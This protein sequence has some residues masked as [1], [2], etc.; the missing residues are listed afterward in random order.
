LLWLDPSVVG[1]G[2]VCGVS[3]VCESGCIWGLEGFNPIRGVESSGLA[4][5]VRVALIRVCGGGC[6]AGQAGLCEVG[7]LGVQRWGGVLAGL[8]GLGAQRAGGLVCGIGEGKGCVRAVRKGGLG[9]W[10]GRGVGACQGSV[11]NVA[12]S[13]KSNCEAAR[14]I[15]AVARGV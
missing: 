6:V 12:A 2:W 8:P 14:A 10:S 7:G 9:A 11:R 15:R 5:G 13:I 3:W 1:V 4:N